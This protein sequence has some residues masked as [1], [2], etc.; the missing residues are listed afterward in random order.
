M[1]HSKKKKAVAV[2]VC[3]AIMCAVIYGR[4]KEK[5]EFIG[6]VE[7][8][9]VSN[10]SEV[11]GKLIESHAEP[12]SKVKKGDIIAVIDDTNQRYTVEQLALSLEKVKTAGSS[13]KLGKGGAADNNYSMA[14]A[15]YDSTVI[16][17]D[18]AKSDYEKAK[19]L[20]EQAAVSESSLES[21]KVAYETAVSTVQAAKAQLDNTSDK[22]AGNVADIDVMLLESQLNQQKE[23]LE[24]YTIKAGCDGIIMSRNYTEGEMVGIGY[25]LADISSQK[26]RYAVIYFPEEKL[27]SIR[28][29]QKVTVTAAELSTEGIV[30]YIDV[31][32]RYTPKELQSAANRNQESIMVKVM[33]PEDFK[34]NVGQKVNVK[35]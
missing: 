17:A 23:I 34:V 4:F 32:S 16:V 6:E 18:K 3:V 19:A 28:Y 10:C 22:T 9:M 24:K 1:K 2:L 35:F 5:E 20:Y 27:N 12:G 26:E 15:N 31:E 8:V 25:N 13:S 30:K 7:G 11:S 29:D 33:L 21:S 14:K